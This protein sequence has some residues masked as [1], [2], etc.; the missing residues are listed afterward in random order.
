MVG[1]FAHIL[2]CRFADP[3]TIIL[4]EISEEEAKHHPT[5]AYNREVFEEAYEIL[6][7]ATD[8]DGKPFK[9][10]RMPCPS[11]GFTKMGPEDTNYTY[12]L[13]LQMD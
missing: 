9:I 11:L 13:G 12:F 8:Q 10:L 2:I 1:W 3:R 7:K 6:S 4:A 5:L